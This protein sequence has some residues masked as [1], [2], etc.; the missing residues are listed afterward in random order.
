M[1]SSDL[2]GTYLRNRLQPEVPAVRPVAGSEAPAQVVSR[3]VQRLEPITENTV[4]VH[5]IG[6]HVE[7]GSKRLWN[8][9]EIGPQAGRAGVDRGR[10]AAE[11]IVGT[12][13]RTNK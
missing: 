13:S 8:V 2:P 1:S 7:G 4:F 9:V 5:L 10:I 11:V 3:S 6:T 12:L